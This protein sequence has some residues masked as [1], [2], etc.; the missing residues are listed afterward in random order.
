MHA[1]E[2]PPP[3]PSDDSHA[4]PSEDSF[5]SYNLP[6]RFAE[7]SPGILDT[8]VFFGIA[9]CLTL[10]IQ[11]GG[12]ALVLHWHLFGKHTLQ[13]IA[14]QPRFTLPIMGLSYGCIF[15]ISFFLFSRAWGRPFLEG[16]CWN[17]SIARNYVGRLLL[18]GVILAGV[19]QLASNYLPVP[20]ELPV[21]SFFRTPLDAWMMAIFGTFVAPTFEELAFRGFLYP[22]LRRWVGIVAGTVLTSIPFAFLHAQQ[23][24]HAFSPLLM[25]F[26]VSI[27]LTEVRERT[28]SVAASALV[29]ATYNLSIFLTVFFAS[30]GFQHLD[31]LRD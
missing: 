23:V 16:V 14:L 8:V 27:V 28:G 3:L 19:I 4:D 18:T 22:A 21:D 2:I 15:G 5:P 6:Q 7:Q 24:A 25:V 29:H 10:G 20:K 31:R 13:Q 26:L 12:A 11:G 9:I 30:G 17:F 1:P